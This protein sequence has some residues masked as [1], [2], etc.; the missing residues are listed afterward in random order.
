VRDLAGA[1]VLDD[2]RFID[3]EP[4]SRRP[5]SRGARPHRSQASTAGGRCDTV[6]SAEGKRHGDLQAKRPRRT[7]AGPVDFLRRWRLRGSLAPAAEQI[8]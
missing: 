6:R 8:A 1:G 5:R 3:L 2:T 4:G 7:A